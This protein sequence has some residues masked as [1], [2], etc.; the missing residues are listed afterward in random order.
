M[1]WRLANAPTPFLITIA[2]P[3]P[4]S[5]P[6][7][8]A[9]LM[10]LLFIEPLCLSYS[11]NPYPPLRLAFCTPAPPISSILHPCVNPSPPCCTPP[12]PLLLLLICVTLVYSVLRGPGATNSDTGVEH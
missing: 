12:L 4:N 7:D 8:V 2:H 10:P 9:P 1:S 5:P 3:W 6:P 11:L